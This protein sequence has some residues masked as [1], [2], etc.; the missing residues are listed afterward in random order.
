[1]PNE[2]HEHFDA[3][4]DG[5]VGGVDNMRKV[6]T[7][8]RIVALHRLRL[9]LSRPGVRFLCKQKGNWKRNGSF[10]CHYDRSCLNELVILQLDSNGIG[11]FTLRVTYYCCHVKRR[12]ISI[13][14]SA[15]N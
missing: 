6:D 1:M 5:V 15:R 13:S 11:P 4:I 7:K 3:C 14:I 12:S 10:R 9:L 2:K 8:N